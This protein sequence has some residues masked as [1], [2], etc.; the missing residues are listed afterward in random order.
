M[1]GIKIA[2]RLLWLP[3]LIQNSI[4][5]LRFDND[6]DVLRHSRFTPHDAGDA[7]RQMK[8]QLAEFCNR[9]EIF[10]RFLKC[11]N[12]KHGPAFA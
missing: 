11:V 7:A 2:S 1:R 9:S 10:K 5:S 6:V 4:Q 8:P 12:W 3:E